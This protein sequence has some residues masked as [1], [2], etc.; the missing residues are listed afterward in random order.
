MDKKTESRL[1]G[2]IRRNLKIIKLSTYYKQY[3]NP[4]LCRVPG[5]LPSAFCRALGK[6]LHSVT[7]SF[8]ERRT[9]GTEIHSTKTSLPSVEPSAKAVLGKEPSAVV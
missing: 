9:L 4:G 2:V 8:T 6:V 7:S 1:E 3:R 5:A